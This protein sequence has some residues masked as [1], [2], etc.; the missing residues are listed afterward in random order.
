MGG[1]GGKFAHPGVPATLDGTGAFGNATSSIMHFAAMSTSRFPFPHQV[2]V[3]NGMVGV[4]MSSQQVRLEDPGGLFRRAQA[5]HV[6]PR[7]RTEVEGT[8]P[9]TA[10]P[11]PA[12]VKHHD[13]LKYI[14]QPTSLSGTHSPS[15]A[16][17]GGSRDGGDSDCGRGYG[18]PSS[19]HGG[20]AH[21]SGNGNGS[22][23]GS[24][25]PHTADSMFS[26]INDGLHPNPRYN[27]Y[28]HNRE[29]TGFNTSRARVDPRLPNTSMFSTEN[30]R[31][32]PQ[33]THPP[34]KVRTEATLVDRRDEAR[35]RMRGKM[36]NAAEGRVVNAYLREEFELKKLDFE[37]TRNKARSLL[38]YQDQMIAGE[39]APLPHGTNN[40]G[41]GMNSLHRQSPYRPTRL[42]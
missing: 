24:I 29:H 3:G 2:G 10:N 23:L 32:R 35:R 38:R 14:T 26:G 28:V 11:V 31:F 5:T 13:R 33:T 36:R 6:L 17:A 12:D 41:V 20:S 1:A 22:Q 7:H 25:R 15:S 19:A 4:K 21:G 34:T 8:R 42:W 40:R 27:P 39:V 30:R 37:R 18:A 9:A 16:R